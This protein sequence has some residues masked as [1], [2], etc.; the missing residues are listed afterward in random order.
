MTELDARERIMAAAV[1]C[2]AKKGVQRFS[3]EDVA[4]EAAV[5]R[6]TI[7]RQ[8]PGGRP[9]LVQESATWEVARFWMRLADSVADA[10]TLEDR[11]VGG[12]KMGSDM[13]RRS[14]I[15]SN[16][17]ATEIEELAIA[18]R[19][20]EALVHEVIR[21]YLRDLLA[22]E[23]IAGKVRPD[24]DVSEAADYLA[25]MLLSVL[26]APVGRDLSDETA[27]RELVRTQFL[28]GIAV[29]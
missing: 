19:P 8:F 25:R 4:T 10:A 17:N 22:E 3:L 6:T 13:M 24:L 18:L 14:P 23:Q 21:S 15:M 26:G 20:S 11:L 2:A 29:R 1:R 9:Q 16:L 12:L 27:T 5:S 28:G 7:Y